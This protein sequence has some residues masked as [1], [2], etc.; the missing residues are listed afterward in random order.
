MWVS[1]AIIGFIILCIIL[2]YIIRMA[3][4]DGIVDGLKKYDKLKQK[5]INND[6]Q[7]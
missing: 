7:S 1:F 4:E 5:N 6:E 2:Y 3:V